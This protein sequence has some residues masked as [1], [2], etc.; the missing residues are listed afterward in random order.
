MSRIHFPPEILNQIFQFLPSYDFQVVSFRGNHD[1]ALLACSQVSRSWRA[2]ALPRVWSELVLPCTSAGERGLLR[3]ANFLTDAALDRRHN[4]AHFVRSIE[5]LTE[6]V[7]EHET[8]LKEVTAPIV[9]IIQL[10]RPGQLRTLTIDPPN[11]CPLI[12]YDLI[13]IF[14]TLKSLMTNL[15]TFQI[16]GIVDHGE[17]AIDLLNYL[18]VSLSSLTLRECYNLHT[19]PSQSPPTTL[20]LH[21][22][23]ALPR[24]CHL[25]LSHLPSS[26]HP[27]HLIC[28]LRTWSTSLRHLSLIACPSLHDDRVI[29]ALAQNCPNLVRLDVGHAFESPSLRHITDGAMC[30]LIDACPAL[31]TLSCA[32][33]RALSDVFLGYCARNGRMLR[34]LA[35]WN[36]P[37]IRGRGVTDVN[38]WSN[39]EVLE[40]FDPDGDMVGE[41]GEMDLDFGRAVLTECRKLFFC[42]IGYEGEVVLRS[43]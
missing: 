6:T 43:G 20:P 29:Y 7:C 31:E 32:N 30:A 18:P 13:P 33:L 22:I 28:A 16:S 9:R 26:I 38:G 24:I 8:T 34:H 4:L 17:E 5:I 2:V 39:L 14:D 19:L 3:L 36:S 25:E 42:R 12:C 35:V 15:T 40:V 1:Y 11:P 10:L 23:L 41:F 21:H 37:R 27:T